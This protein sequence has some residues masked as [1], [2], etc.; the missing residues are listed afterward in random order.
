MDRSR[1]MI[2]LVFLTVLLCI[3]FKI[4]LQPDA[5]FN[6]VN[7]GTCL[8]AYLIYSLH[9]ISFCILNAQFYDKIIRAILGTIFIDILSIILFS[10]MTQWPVAIQYILIFLSPSIAGYSLLQ[11][12][13]FEQSEIRKTKILFSSKW[14]YMI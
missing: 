13:R 8:F 1:T 11:V 6:T 3:I 7:I 5:Y 9:L 10:N 2:L 4:K 12:S 14:S